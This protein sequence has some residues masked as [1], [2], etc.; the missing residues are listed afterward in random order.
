MSSERQA[1]LLRQSLQEIRRL[2]QALAQEQQRE[3]IAIVGVGLRLPRTI[4]DLDQLWSLLVEGRDAISPPPAD[5]FD[6]EP[7]YTTDRHAAGM[8]YVR[9]AAF[10]DEA[11]LFDGEPFGISP[12]EA[13][14]LDPQ[15][16]MLLETTRE[17]LERAGIP[18]DRLQGSR[19]GV[20]VGVGM[21]DYPSSAEPNGFMVSGRDTGFCAGRIAH[22][23]GLN[24][25]AAAINTTCSSS[26]VAL[27]MAI[28]SLRSGESELAIVGGTSLIGDPSSFV[29]LCATQ[30]LAP[31]GR[32]K[33]FSANAD[34]Y[35]RGE[36]T[37][38]LVA[39]PL[40]RAERDHHPVLALIRGSAIR[41]DGRSSGITVPNGS[42]Q[43]AVIRAALADSGL[44]PDDIDTVECHGTGTPL[45]DPIEVN[46]LNAVY[47][48]GRQQPLLLGSIKPHI[49]HL[50]TAAGLAGL[51][52]LLAA[53][54]HETLPGAIH[55]EPLTPHID[56]AQIA[57]E[58]V[59][60][61]RPWP[62]GER[63][64]R[65]AISSFGMSGTNAHL[66]IEEGPA[67][68][69]VDNI[70]QPT[71]PLL[72]SAG[73]KALLAREAQLWSEWLSLHPQNRL[74][75]TKY[76]A[77]CHRSHWQWRAAIEAESL[78]QAIERLDL[79]AAGRPHPAITTA[80]PHRQDG[81]VLLFPG[82]GSQW[83]GMGAELLQQL[84][85]FA[86][87]ID[88]CD[89]ALRPH[90]GWSVRELLAG[91]EGA[92]PLEQ[93]DHLQPALFAMGVALAESMLSLGVEVA[94]VAGHSVGEIAAAVVAGALPLEVGARLV[95]RRGELIATLADPGGMLAVQL[96]AAAVRQR[97]VPFGERLVVAVVNA[98]Q[99]CV[100]AGELA[101]IDRLERSLQSDG[102]DA[103][104]VRIGFAAHS[105]RMDELLLPFAETLG[106]LTP[107]ATSIPFYSS[108]NGQMVAGESLDTDYWLDNLRQSVRFDLTL[109]TLMNEG[110][111]LYL[112]LG[113]H[114]LLSQLIN[115]G[116]TAQ[117]ETAPAGHSA[118]SIPTL[119]RNR[120]GIAAIHRALAQLH[121][122]GY[123]VD[124]SRH[125]ERQE[126]IALPTTPF[127]RRS[128]WNHPAARVSG[129]LLPGQEQIDHPLLGS[130]LPLADGG[131]LFVSRLDPG[132]QPWLADHRVVEQI[133]VPGTLLLE[134]ALAAGRAVDAPRVEELTLLTP[135][136][137][138]QSTPCR[139]QLR[140]SAA[141]ADGKRQLTLHADSSDDNDWRLHAEGSVAPG[142]SRQVEDNHSD[143]A[144]PP[145]GAEPIDQTQ[146]YRQLASE[147]LD[148]GPEFR[149]LTAAWSGDD[150]WY[151]EVAL[152]DSSHQDV[153][154]LIH[155][156]LLDASL[157]TIAINGG[158]SGGPRLPFRWQGVECHTTLGE[159]LRI[160]IR[161][162]EGQSVTITIGNLAGEPQALIERLT[163]REAQIDPAAQA[164]RD[165]Y[166]IGWQ[167][168]AGS[169]V[170]EQ[171]E[172]SAR[173]PLQVYGAGPVAWALGRD[174][175]VTIDDPS[176][177][178]AKAAT[179][180][181]LL[182]D[183][184]AIEQRHATAMSE[185]VPAL[186]R[187]VAA[188]VLTLLQSTCTAPTVDGSQLIWISRGATATTAGETIH[189]LPQAA[190][191]G[192]LRSA[193][194]EFP[195]RSIR[196]I[197]LP[198]PPAPID[199][200]RL[201]Q[202]IATGEESEIA[203]RGDELL[204][205]RFDQAAGGDLAPLI[206]PAEWRAW[207]LD[208]GP[209]TGI[210]KLQICQIERQPLARGEVRVAV[211]AAGM[212]FRDA[213]NLLGMVEAPWLGLELA[214]EVI[215]C[216]A[217]VERLQPGDR[218]M[219]MGRWSFAT[220]AVAE[221]H[222]L[223]ITPS[224]LS[225]R[226]AATT[227]LV[228]L[229]ACH[230]IENLARLQP[231][232]RILIHA[233][234]GGVGLA[235]IQFARQCGA[236]IYATASPG[237]WPLLLSLGIDQER[238]ASSRSLDFEQQF[239]AA[240][241]GRGV[242]MV[243]NSLAGEFIDASM[244]LLA[245]GGR[246]VELGKTDLRDAEW[247]AANHPAINYFSF[248]LGD[249]AAG[250]QQTMLERVAADLA[251]DRLQPLPASCFDLREAPAAFN[252]MIRARHVGKQL[253][254][255]PR[256]WLD[257]GRPVLITGA[258]GGLGRVVAHHLVTRHAV[259]RLILTSRRGEAGTGAGELRDQ[260]LA[261]GANEVVWVACDVA[262]PDQV[263]ALLDQ[264]R[265]G[266]IIHLAGVLDDSTLTTL[267]HEQLERVLAP[268]VDGAWYLHHYSRE[269][270]VTAFIL[271]SSIASLIDSPGQANYAAANQFLNALAARRRAEGLPATALAWGP[272]LPQEGGMTATLS[273]ADLERMRREGIEPLPAE[274]AM[275]LFDGAVT[276]PES[277]LIPLRLDPAR[278]PPPLARSP[279]FQQLIRS[280][281][282]GK[283]ATE[284]D[285]Q[286][287]EE[288]LARL[289]A[290]PEGGRLHAV[291][292]QVSAA[293]ALVLGHEPDHPID[294]DTG[295]SL[296]G[297][298]SL[299]AVE[300]RNQLQA[301]TGLTLPV[302][303]TFDHPTINQLASRLALQLSELAGQD[304]GALP[305]PPTP[306][307]AEVAIAD[308]PPAAA[309]VTPPIQ[310]AVSEGESSTIQA[311]LQPSQATATIAIQLA[312][313]TAPAGRRPIELGGWLVRP[314]TM[315]DVDQLYRLEVE[316]YEH[317]GEEAIASRQLIGERIGL[318]NRGDRAW[319]WLLEQNGEIHAWN[320]LQPTS[321]DPMSYRSWAEATDNGQLA[322]TFD[323]SGRWIYLVA[324]GLGKGAPNS[325]PLLL[326]LG[327]LLQLRQSH[328]EGIFACLSISGYR[329][330]QAKSGISPETYIEQRDANGLPID[331]FLA[332]F[333]QYWPIRPSIRVLRNGYPPDL[334]SCGHGASTVL[335]LDEIDDVI[336]E[337]EQ[338]IINNAAD[339][340]YQRQ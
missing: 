120:G 116:A 252:Q 125:F 229:T 27:H 149:R 232:E 57:V 271:F 16:R 127:E 303:L 134:L 121:L 296:L 299:M 151:A 281:R 249:L 204:A 95:A 297:I 123:P 223:T 183:L 231:G 234:T 192:L 187:A 104:R 82:H 85:P 189:S 336:G 70:D 340:W 124:W 59:N 284:G 51:T 282:G 32:S 200:E 277:L 219:G 328:Y 254:I 188:E 269:L 102:V 215:E 165:L 6:I 202:A 196:L 174:G 137:I 166:R 87:A 68:P 319:F 162:S 115:G 169:D 45:G 143:T 140:L 99:S 273:S 122:R 28:E 98:A 17:A 334:E 317:I 236:E 156:A 52:R 324:G 256:P 33:T 159:R 5:R 146:L 239:L 150:G 72:L 38:T 173:K 76:S 175:A 4:C 265:P 73:S 182:I 295:F 331:P 222:Q 266:A 167:G 179:P 26:L 42:S 308:P 227:P 43:E 259:R 310:Q 279:L 333:L 276:R 61:N 198:A 292:T 283:P 312:R 290:I 318:L 31:D 54:Q 153:H 58:V 285:G 260:L 2:K 326:N 129:T 94:A 311:P 211:T 105:P 50:E 313:I 71:L 228:F 152:A 96:P 131:V 218:V 126:L 264:H 309:A 240:S 144:W 147:G 84:P 321:V 226:Q 325:A 10:V 49:G 22:V 78:P 29:D 12:R 48:T 142:L 193:R 132:R 15:Q 301:G 8:S 216:G 186:T 201:W 329:K 77:A 248:D 191:V 106:E 112:E 44:S 233:A 213:L 23:Y 62:R 7:I 65:A 163:L 315:E 86:A 338:R 75:A 56:W 272:W 178:V 161:R 91:S 19:T 128:Y 210:D 135:L 108:L 101:A 220:E 3:A 270:N 221:S 300:L 11:T 66:I 243:L 176:A 74:A 268:K 20:F 199:S 242:D 88:R 55:A 298:D 335:P 47:G 286:S 253:L 197:D 69:P 205:S 237:K 267:T 278:L 247:L 103:R 117:S 90:T 302:T 36:G 21:C 294:P 40:S 288:Q 305:P 158:A 60:G 212:N 332:I 337:L 185:A 280:T 100:V 190:I 92:P 209:S 41:H 53:L 148:Y 97:L 35:G 304:E 119:Q 257:S 83:P 107:S 138:D 154:W 133:I 316:G 113:G 136:A 172:R 1:D 330:A 203:L 287:A 168:L 139:L 274:L 67:P 250:L 258:G 195:E 81:V 109:N 262:C 293:V 245:A 255:P 110:H 93:V 39:M 34:G 111:G 314:A 64:R 114:P 9:E 320:I 208:P 275:R 63:P 306:E 157:H 80:N 291:T 145:T 206:P 246:F 323:E 230:A 289:L 46:A 224:Q 30:A 322:N 217:G 130:K 14:Q 170:I 238:I 241:G 180:V 184:T 155:P 79:L 261:A 177:I 37:V 89:K 25:P 339:L 171:R 160:A 263:A 327:T 13:Q 214:G 235:A 207:R 225:D 307:L 181:T 251:S 244:R 141:G 164:L 194:S 118:V 24:G 18:P